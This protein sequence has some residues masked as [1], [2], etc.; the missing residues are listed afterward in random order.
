MIQKMQQIFRKFVHASITRLRAETDALVNNRGQVGLDEL[1]RRNRFP[2]NPFHQFFRSYPRKRRGF[3]NKLIK[4]HP[5]RIL[6]AGKGIDSMHQPLR[7]HIPQ[8]SALSSFLLNNFISLLKQKSKSKIADVYFPRFIQ[9]QVRRFDI[10]VQNAAAV[11]VR[12]RPGGL[13]ANAGRLPGGTC[14]LSS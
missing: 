9:Q 11:G 6:I 1:Q 12:N 2:A 13:E 4:R 5:K 10:A 7:G 8:R 14:F 3:C